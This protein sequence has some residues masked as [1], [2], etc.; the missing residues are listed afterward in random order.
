MTIMNAKHYISPVTA[1]Q[2]CGSVHFICASN[3]P[4]AVGGDVVT[5]GD[6][7]GDPGAPGM[8]L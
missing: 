4:Q 1:F 7:G 2:P 5:G 3:T 8:G 6:V